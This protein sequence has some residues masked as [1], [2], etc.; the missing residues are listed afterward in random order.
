MLKVGKFNV[1]IVPVGGRYGYEDCLTNRDKPLVEFY[2]STQDPKKFGER[3]QFVTRYYIY[4]ILEREENVGL[5]LLGNVPSWTV[6]AAGMREVMA[7]LKG[8]TEA[9]SK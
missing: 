4:T 7:Y 2:D 9:T 3:G 1:R 5:P 6:P 8:W